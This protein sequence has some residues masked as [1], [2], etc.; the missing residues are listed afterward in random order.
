MKSQALVTETSH[1]K[2]V[3]HALHGSVAD[4][5][6]VSLW[7]HYHLRDRAPRLLADVT[8]ALQ[9]Q[10]DFDL[11]KLTP[12]GLYGVQD[13]GAGLQFGQSDNEAPTVIRS[14]IQSAADWKALKPLSPE[15]GALRREWEMCGRVAQLLEGR[16]PF[17]MTLFSPLTLA[18]KLAGD[19][20]YEHMRQEP[21]ALHAGLR[22]I[23]DTVAAYARACAETAV[24]GFFFATQQASHALLS[25][26]EYR[27][28]GQAYDQDIA[29]EIRE[30]PVRMLHVCGRRIMLEEAGE[31]DFNCLSWSAGGDNPTLRAARRHTDKTLAAGLDLDMLATGAPPDVE[32]MVQEA[33]AQDAGPAFILAPDCVVKGESPDANLETAVRAAR[34]P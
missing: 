30:L 23:R 12:S 14:P 33:L 11:I 21:A 3:L 8:V 10:F 24:S 6:P 1:W 13:W 4:C 28:F 18:Q 31:L 15:T 2:R 29:A 25:P 32:R 19:A 7:K 5:V 16:V 17:I 22:T 27:E 9:R 26:A 20:A 34:A